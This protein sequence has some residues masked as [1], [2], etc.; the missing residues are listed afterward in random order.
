M[1]EALQRDKSALRGDRDGRGR[2][3][4]RNL[5]AQQCEGGCKTL[6]LAVDV[7]REPGESLGYGV[8]NRLAV[9]LLGL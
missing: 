3:G 6:L 2:E 8:Q 1:A 7:A 4:A 9:G 5:A